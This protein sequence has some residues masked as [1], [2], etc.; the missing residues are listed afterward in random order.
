MQTVDIQ[1][2]NIAHAPDPKMVPIT[3]LAGNALDNG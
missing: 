3:P 2:E 1:T